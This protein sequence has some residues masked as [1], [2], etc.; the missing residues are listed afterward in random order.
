MRVLL[1]GATGNLGSRLIPALLAH[2]HVVTVYIRSASKLASLVSPQVVERIKVVIGDATDPASLKAALL[3]HDC[4]AVVDVAGNQVLPWKEYLLP[5]IAASVVEATT[6]VGE[7]RGKV[8]RVWVTGGIG[9]LGYPGTEW[10][11]ED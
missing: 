1:L 3:E 9:N 4:E 8:V 11:I 5:K 7:E 2:N 6:A 10:N